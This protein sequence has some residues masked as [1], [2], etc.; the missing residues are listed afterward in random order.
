MTKP[1]WKI[2]LYKIINPYM[3]AKEKITIHYI[4]LNMLFNNLSKTAT[5]HLT[6]V[7]NPRHKNT[8]TVS[9]ITGNTNISN[10]CFRWIMWL[11][12]NINMSMFPWSPNRNRGVTWCHSPL[13]HIN[14]QWSQI[15]TNNNNFIALWKH[16]CKLYKNVTMIIKIPQIILLQ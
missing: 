2:R 14:H 15:W 7:V 16:Y 5:S 1:Y 11:E 10:V 4:K 6:F 3:W 9:R 12:T 13:R 8:R